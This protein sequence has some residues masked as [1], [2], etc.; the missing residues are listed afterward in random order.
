MR[1]SWIGR[2]SKQYFWITLWIM[3]IALIEID[4][5]DLFLRVVLL[6]VEIRWDWSSE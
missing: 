3:G 2:E 1:I 5:C 6:G 4:V